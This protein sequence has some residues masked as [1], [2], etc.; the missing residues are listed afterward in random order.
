MATKQQCKLEHQIDRDS[1]QHEILE[2]IRQ[3]HDEGESKYLSSYATKSSQGIRK[4][5]LQ[6]DGE[7][8][9]CFSRDADRI[10]HS[11]AY[12][13]Y[14]DKTQVFYQIENDHITHRSLHVQLVSKIARHIGKALHL[15]QDL[16]EAIAL[17]HDVGHPPFGHDG[18]KAL[19]RLCKECGS[20]EFHHSVEGVILLQQVCNRNLTLQVLDGILCHDGEKQYKPLSPKKDKDWAGHMKEIDSKVRGDESDMYPM[21][22]EGCVVRITDKIAYLGRDIEDALRL[23]VIGIENMTE[24]L[25]TKECLNVLY[26]N[27]KSGEIDIKRINRN[28]VDYLVNDIISNSYEKDH[29]RLSEDGAEVMEK[30]LSFNRKMIYLNHDVNRGSGKIDRIYELVFQQFLK[31]LN[32]DDKKSRIFRHFLDDQLEQSSPEYFQH[33][34]N[35]EKVRDFIAGMTDDY[36]I[37]TATELDSLIPRKCKYRMEYY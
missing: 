7:F 16:I 23:S 11:T 19:S 10:L 12:T 14:I 31:D 36:M 26:G 3:E 15:N 2:K 9:P 5:K 29:I 21:T 17:G 30:F 24:E 1:H 20:Y 22:M 25:L 28:I 37:D 35:L 33:A 27:N 18:E 13:R 32:N 4:N 6:D 8:R 34:S